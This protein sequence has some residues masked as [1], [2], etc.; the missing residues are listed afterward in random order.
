MKTQQLASL[1]KSLAHPARTMSAAL[2]A[3]LAARVVG[4]PE[5]YWAP[6]SALIVM[7]S[8]LGASLASSWQLLAGTA[9][10]AFTGGLLAAHFG[11]S[12]I[13]FGLVVFGIGLLSAALRL[14]PSANRFAV[15]T[16]AIVLFAG[17]AT[18]AWVRALHRFAEFSTG[19]IVGLLIS[20]LW[21][22]QQASRAEAASK[23]TQ[24]KK[25]TNEERKHYSHEKQ[26]SS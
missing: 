21:P 25:Q 26:K 7:Q 10:G 8:N 20:A 12:V 11:P 3:L 23:S 6:I 9:L 1:K 4:L 2:L 18:D 24:P 13:G 14:E 15:I 17:P 5:F 22:E 16:L 19:I